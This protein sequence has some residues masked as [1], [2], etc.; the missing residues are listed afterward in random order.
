MYKLIKYNFL[1]KGMLLAVVVVCTVLANLF[2]GIRYGE[3]QIAAFLSVAWIGLAILLVVDIILMYS[4]DLNSTEGYM[5]FMT[6]NSGY[7]ILASKVVTAIIEGFAI[8]VFYSAII[9]IN[10]KIFFNGD[11]SFTD[12]E[13]PLGFSL[14][15]FTVFLAI[16]LILIIQFILT[17]FTAL[18]VRKSLLAN[19]KFGGLLS[20]VVFIILNIIITKFYEL[21]SNILSIA[22]ANVFN[23]TMESEYGISGAIVP[24][25]ELITQMAPIIGITLFTT[26]VLAVVSGYL[27]EKKINL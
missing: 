16:A 4:R 12:I 7:K 17:I 5:V 13:L 9:F 18:T 14:A 3:I 11:I 20:F 26:A 27:L 1:R 10:Y 23:I 2:V 19:V 24:V 6:P 8:L 15:H 22:D 21:I 25:G